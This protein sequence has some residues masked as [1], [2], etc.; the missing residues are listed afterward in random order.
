MFYF[1]SDLM[2]CIYGLIKNSVYLSEPYVLVH[3][4]ISNIQ[5]VE[6][7]ESGVQ[8]H[9]KLQWDLKKKFNESFIFKL[10]IKFIKVEVTM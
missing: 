2:H 1:S 3:T 4:C 10:V 7:G 9:P 5:E 6:T 8:D